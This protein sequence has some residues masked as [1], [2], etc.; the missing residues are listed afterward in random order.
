MLDQEER[1][2]KHLNS[3]YA[4]LCDDEKKFFFSLQNRWLEV[5]CLQSIMVSCTS[6]IKL[7]PIL[8]SAPWGAGFWALVFTLVMSG[9]YIGDVWFLHWWCQYAIY[10]PRLSFNHKAFEL[11]FGESGNKSEIQQYEETSLFSF[12]KSKRNGIVLENSYKNW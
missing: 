9:F 4:F 1:L 8:L 3:P 7:Y 5:K 12:S 10:L 6:L 2:K 11:R